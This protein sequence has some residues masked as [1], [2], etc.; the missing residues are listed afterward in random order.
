MQCLKKLQSQVIIKPSG[1]TDTNTYSLFQASLKAGID[2][3]EAVALPSD[4]NLNDWLAV[5]GILFFH[6]VHVIS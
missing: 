1:N 5:H 6:L 4:E 3:R 2:L